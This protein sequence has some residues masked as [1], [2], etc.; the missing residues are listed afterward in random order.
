M[1]AHALDTHL[2]LALA[3]EPRP[4]P[5]VQIRPLT[6]GDRA[7][8]VD[9]FARLSP[10]TVYR[11]FHQP[12]AGVGS[13]FL[14]R[15]LDLDGSA[16]VALAA[17]YGD[18]LIGVARYHQPRP[19]EPAEAAV[20]VEDAWQRHGIG[21][22]LLLA[23]SAAAA[24]NGVAELHGSVQASNEALLRLVYDVFPDVDMNLRFGEYLY[25]LRVRVPQ[26]AR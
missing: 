22:R 19:G 16:K 10:T 12:V 14:D 8:L 18:D 5:T 17:T 7:R 9:L 23:L 6:A 20:V 21:R 13:A 26:T 4:L 3:D 25:D 2:R 11:R 24:G 15:L 1:V